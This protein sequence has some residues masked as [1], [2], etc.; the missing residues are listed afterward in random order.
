VKLTD[1]TPEQKCRYAIC[2]AW[3]VCQDSDWRE[4]AAGRLEKPSTVWADHTYSPKIAGAGAAEGA[5]E[6][7]NH[8]VGL[9]GAENHSS[10]AWWQSE[11]DW[12]VRRV[13]RCAAECLNAETGDRD[14][15]LSDYALWA[16]S[17]KPLAEMPGYEGVL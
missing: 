3:Q 15:N 4:W 9:H 5:V 2:L 10:A 6:V 13:E 14:V 8:I 7:A 12:W 17:G 16:V 11:L 1:M